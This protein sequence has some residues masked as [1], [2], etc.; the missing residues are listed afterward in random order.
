[1]TFSPS[2]DPVS[3]GCRNHHDIKTQRSEPADLCQC[4]RPNQA[5]QLFCS[6]QITFL[7]KC[8]FRHSC[9]KISKNF[10]FS[11]IV[12]NKFHLVSNKPWTIQKQS[13]IKG[14]FPPD[15]F[16]ELQ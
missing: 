7:L 10:L 5:R 2:P 1:M 13:C 14:G 9:K 8:L 4:S 15:K 6:K 16:D 11:P 3:R 12:R